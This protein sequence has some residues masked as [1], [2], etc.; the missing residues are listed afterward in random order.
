MRNPDVLITLMYIQRCTIG[1]EAHLT[2]VTKDCEEVDM[3][4]EYQIAGEGRV[5]VEI[6]D[7]R[8]DPET[9]ADINRKGIKPVPFQMSD[10]HSASIVN[11]YFN[12]VVQYGDQQK[13]LGFNDLIDVKHSGIGEPEVR[14]RD[15][16]YSITSNIKIRYRIIYK[17]F[18][19][20]K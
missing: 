10:R 4:K 1:H 7:P 6:I 5:S 13:I 17:L 16:E 12:I 9:E 8:K 3:L 18:A 2:D 15:F 14:L 11:S 19:F 20:S